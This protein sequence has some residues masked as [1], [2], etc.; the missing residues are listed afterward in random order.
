MSDLPARSHS[1]SN[2]NKHGSQ[3]LSHH[4]KTGK[5]NIVSH[6]E[7]SS[8]SPSKE[9]QSDPE[10]E[11]ERNLSVDFSSDDSMVLDEEERR[12]YK[13]IKS[14]Y[15]S[16]KVKSR[17][18]MSN[19]VSQSPPESIVPASPLEDWNIE[20]PQPAPAAPIFKKESPR[21][22]SSKLFPKF[23][24]PADFGC[25]YKNY[26][27]EE[28]PTYEKKTGFP[29]APENKV[30]Y[31]PIASEFP[32]LSRGARNQSYHHHQGEVTPEYE[33]PEE[34]MEEDHLEGAEARDLSIDLD[35]LDEEAEE[36]QEENEGDLH[37]QKEESFVEDYFG[38]EY[39][40]PPTPT[41]VKELEEEEECMLV[42]HFDTEDFLGEIQRARDCVSTSSA[43]G[44]EEK[45]GAENLGLSQLS[46]SP[47]R[48]VIVVDSSVFISSLNLLKEVSWS[49]SE[50][51]EVKIL[52]PW[53]VLQVLQR[54]NESEGEIMK[55]RARAALRW[56][57]N[58]GLAGNTNL[59]TQTVGQSRAV[60]AH[61]QAASA[62]DNILATCLGVLEE[63]HK[64]FLA[65]DYTE[66]S[67]KAILN[68]LKSGKVQNIFDFLKLK[69]DS[70]LAGAAGENEE[71]ELTTLLEDAMKNARDITRKIL[72]A[73]IRK[74]FKVCYG[75]MWQNMFSIKPAPERP[76]W[77]LP[78]LL[79]L[80]S[81]HHVTLLPHFF[82][83]NS[84]EL[85]PKLQTLKESLLVKHYWRIQDVREV[86]QEVLTLIE[87]FQKKDEY[88]G[89]IGLCKEKVL[90]SLDQ[91]T[92]EELK[93]NFKKQIVE[94]TRMDQQPTQARVE[95]LF[96]SIWEI[97]QVYTWAFAELFNIPHELMNVEQKKIQ[98]HSKSEAIEDL[99]RFNSTV[100]ELY[101]SLLK[102]LNPQD[103]GELLKKKNWFILLVIFIVG[104]GAVEGGL[105]ESSLDD[106]YGRLLRFRDS[107]ELD[108]SQWPHH[109]EEEVRRP[110]LHWFLA[111][112]ENQVMMGAGLQQLGECRQTLIQ[113]SHQS[114]GPSDRD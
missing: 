8:A 11:P 94:M 111:Q 39:E 98:F 5:P 89:M 84:H 104:A 25:K 69:A 99:P 53:L 9:H 19:T 83:T 105:A 54:L 49:L 96:N 70:N 20:V 78:N 74:E 60:A 57:E 4:A 1:V 36:E 95:N 48:S 52:V 21:K 77:S 62:E 88:D 50:R 67:N 59:L 40:A 72:E 101:Q 15:K 109:Q 3:V 103:E 93:T 100:E 79:M 113:C 17:V 85:K 13:R 102:L 34:E 47:G 86:F 12:E 112:Q 46:S 65:T 71:N 81:T 90:E 27:K 108:L 51:L 32:D 97:I 61:Y 44:V 92:T 30:K 45:S 14:K 33:S 114:I 37:C 42:E 107:L 87:F 56:L 91:L 68:H 28:R 38:S 2:I 58:I 66:L 31:S 6:F 7:K 110:E 22:E 55:L 64:V 106:F 41:L 23:A 29:K 43:V 16:P 82:P 63:G 80:F 73:V 18:K 75:G 26:E 24:N 35:S 76:Y 10:S